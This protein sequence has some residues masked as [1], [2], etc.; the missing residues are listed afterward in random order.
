MT[1]TMDRRTFIGALTG[2][3]LATPLR[4]MAQQPARTWRIGYLAAGPRSPDGDPPAA[5]RQT[6]QELG[7]VDG[8]NLTY[9]ARW[10]EARSERLPALAAE[11]VALKVD[12][13]VTFGGKVAQT[14]QA[15]DHHRTGRLHRF[16]RS[17]WRR[18][19]VVRGE[20]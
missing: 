1:A 4:T 18:Q 9:V 19:H 14:I 16:R 10:G 20:M 12:V 6:L 5:L 11:L 15:P 8:Q 7:Y 2:T 13:I 17:G 3:F